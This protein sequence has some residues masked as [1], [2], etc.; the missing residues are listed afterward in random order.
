MTKPE[1]LPDLNV[2]LSELEDRLSQIEHNAPVRI[3]RARL[4]ELVGAVARLNDDDSRQKLSVSVIGNHA[5]L[6]RNQLS[7]R[8]YIS[9]EE[10]P[11]LSAA[12][13]YCAV[14]QRYLTRLREYLSTWSLGYE[15]GA[16]VETSLREILPIPYSDKTSLNDRP[17]LAEFIDFIEKNERSDRDAHFLKQFMLKSEWSGGR[18][19]QAGK[20]LKGSD[21][22]YIEPVVLRIL[23]FLA[24]A[25]SGRLPIIEAL[26]QTGFGPNDFVYASN[27]AADSTPVVDKPLLGPAIS[28]GE[29]VLLFG[30]PGT[31]KSYRIHEL[32]HEKGARVVRTVFH[33]ELHASE[34]IGTLKPSLNDDGRTSYRFQPGPFTNAWRQAWENPDEPVFLVIEE[35]NRANAAS[36]LSEVFVLL[37]RDATG[38]SRY[39]VD[40]PTKEME[41]WVREWAGPDGPKS[42][43]LPSN[44]WL[45]GTINSSDQGVFHLDTAFRRR[46]KY[47]H[48]PIRYESVPSVPI[49]LGENVVDWWPNILRALNDRLLTKLN[50]N[51]DRLIGTYFA[52]FSGDGS[53]VETFPEGVA[54]YLWTDVLR[55]H[56]KDLIFH[57]EIS[58]LSEL[59]E[60]ISSDQLFL[61][62]ELVESL[63]DSAAL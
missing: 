34:F 28:G 32:A 17:E 57:G 31:G 55:H 19:S 2:A 35:L 48:M 16:A 15:G 60:R 25:A 52:Q 1:P 14:L 53:S 36:V 20:S 40:F 56:P 13:E 11:F 3:E 5:L 62:N 51:E 8:T 38:Q 21:S 42:L 49:K 50:V 9:V 41:A 10:L 63:Q 43:S 54:V 58:K 39:E 61:C 33:T 4:N 29:N 47:E 26:A 30:P 59:L 37:D 24:G 46:W 23:G 27:L 22:E 12:S 18:T 44:L 7:Q 6:V 45:Y